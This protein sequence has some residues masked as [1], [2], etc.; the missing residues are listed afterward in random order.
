MPKQSESIK[1]NCFICGKT[2]A[3]T[4][5][6]NHVLRDHNDGDEKCYLIKAE[7][8]FDKNYWLFF[9]VALDS[10]LYAIDDFLRKIWCECCGHLSSFRY[11]GQTLDESRELSSLDVGIKLLYEYD[12][13]STT[14]IFVTIVSEISRPKQHEEVRLLARNEPHEEI[15]DICGA[16]ASYINAWEGG[17]VCDGCSMEAEDDEA[18]LSVVNSPRIGECAYDGELDKWTF[19]PEK[20]FPQPPLANAANKNRSLLV[21]AQKEE[22]PAEEKWKKIE[23]E[24]QDLILTTVFCRKCGMTTITD[25]TI[26]NDLSDMVLRGKCA[27]CGGKVA[28]FIEG[29]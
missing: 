22:I 8:A 13:G 7:G 10:T 5:M 20:P 6:K 29:E 3:K 4:A 28:R 25:Y 24:N 21:R 2:A 23:K 18:L 12:F 26:E 27:R 15:C 19:D 11:G 1:G 14:E 9:T 17:Y 16:P